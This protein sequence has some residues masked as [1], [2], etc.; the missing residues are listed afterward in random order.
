MPWIVRRK[1]A[2]DTDLCAG[3]LERMDQV[4][5]EGVQTIHQEDSGLQVASSLVGRKRRR[6]ESSTNMPL[7]V[8]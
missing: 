5:G 3:R 4:P 7:T 1:T 8:K 2:H 6:M